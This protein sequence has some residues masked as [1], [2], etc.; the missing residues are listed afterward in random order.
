MIGLLGIVGLLLVCVVLWVLLGVRPL[1]VC[2]VVCV[3]LGV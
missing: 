3:L 2:V 1:F